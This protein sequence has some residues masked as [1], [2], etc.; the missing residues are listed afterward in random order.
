MMQCVHA[1]NAK[2]NETLLYNLYSTCPTVYVNKHLTEEY[3]HRN[4]IKSD[5]R[6][7]MVGSMLVH[8]FFVLKVL[9]MICHLLRLT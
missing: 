2:R 6:I 9:P 3:P 8:R 5:L 7:A 1:I 4:E